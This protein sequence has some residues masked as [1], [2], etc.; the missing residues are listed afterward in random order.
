[1]PE[2][3][4]GDFAS[5]QTFFVGSLMTLQMSCVFGRSIKNVHLSGAPVSCAS[6]VPGFR[7]RGDQARSHAALQTTVLK[8][9]G[10]TA[11]RENTILSRV[12]LKKD[13]N[14]GV[15]HRD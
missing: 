7:V 14:R 1:M 6:L 2:I 15:R 12:L 8:R 13:P 11:P 3:A 4:F 5:Q 9:L 10:P